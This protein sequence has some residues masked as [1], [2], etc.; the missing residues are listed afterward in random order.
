MKALIC[1]SSKH[2]EYTALPPPELG[3]AHE[4]IVR[5]TLATLTRTDVAEA[6]AGAVVGRSAVGVVEALGTE[7]SRLE[8]GDRVVVC[9]RFACGRCDHC[10]RGRYSRCERVR[11]SSAV[12]LH[13]E[14]VRIP[15]ADSALFRLPASIP[16]HHAIVLSDIAPEG[17]FAAELAGIRAGDAVA[18][19]GCGPVGQIAIACAKQRGA[20]ACFAIDHH[21][22]RLQN[23][24]EQGA[25]IFHLKDGDPTDAIIDA[26]AGQ[27][28]DR[29]IDTRN[30]SS[31]AALLDAAVRVLARGGT[32]ALTGPCASDL[33]H[34]PIGLARARQ[35]AI[36]TGS[37]L[38]GNYIPH[39]IQLM[40]SQ[41]LAPQ[42][43]L[44]R[45]SGLAEA[46]TA[47]TDFDGDMPEWL[48]VAPGG[49]TAMIWPAPKEPGSGSGQLAEGLDET[50]PASDPPS[51]T[52]PH[53]EDDDE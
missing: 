47:I 48:C 29:V 4:A 37:A 8:K 42:H 32:L 7:V 21:Q 20:K 11:E 3:A 52:L 53:R 43:L 41:R 10:R 50:F 15:H 34:F 16:D 23:A 22:L 19:F 14:L 44:L 31:S 18:V 35:L 6:S 17:Y 39:L 27:G 45:G 28:V 46:R 5:V 24:R 38:P 30:H 40:T 26:N 36:K 33:N 51:I 13:A 49:E 25:S 1:G 2:F 12:G 9:S